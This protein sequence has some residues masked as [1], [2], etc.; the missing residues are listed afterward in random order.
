MC[1]HHQTTPYPHLCGHKG[2]LARFATLRS[3]FSEHSVFHSLANTEVDLQD[4]QRDEVISISAVMLLA[5]WPHSCAC[6][7]VSFFVCMLDKL[8]TNACA[9]FCQTC[10]RQCTFTRAGT[11]FLCTCRARV[12]ALQRCRRRCPCCFAFLSTFRTLRPLTFLADL[13]PA[14]FCIGVECS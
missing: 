8:R 12:D 7:F 13:V 10:L 14:A 6:L 11:V 5:I 4:P 3:D 2:G 9:C 1:F